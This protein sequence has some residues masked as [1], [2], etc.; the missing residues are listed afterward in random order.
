MTLDYKTIW[1]Y[2]DRL[3]P[4]GLTVMTPAQTAE[5]FFRSSSDS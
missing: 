3:I 4:F 5:R 2:R 1:R